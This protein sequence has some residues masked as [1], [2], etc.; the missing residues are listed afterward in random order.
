MDENKLEKTLNI[1]RKGK[2]AV[3]AYTNRYTS[4]KAAR[5]GYSSAVCYPTGELTKVFLSLANY[6]KVKHLAKVTP[7]CLFIQSR[8]DI[9]GTLV[10]IFKTESID[11]E[12]KKVVFEK[13]ATFKDG[14]WDNPE[15]LNSCKRAITS[16]KSRAKKYY[17]MIDMK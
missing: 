2:P 8:V 10:E 14:K 11:I 12:N 1:T 9:D 7:D 15:Y 17:N 5:C 3:W 13:V 4:V 6:T 16:V